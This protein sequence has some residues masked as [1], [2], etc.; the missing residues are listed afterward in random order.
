M[1]GKSGLR[2][3]IP[4]DSEFDYSMPALSSKDLVR[5]KLVSYTST[6]IYNNRPK[7]IDTTKVLEGFTLTD[8]DEVKENPSMI[9]VWPKEAL[10]DKN[11]ITLKAA[12]VRI[13]L[14]HDG[15]LPDPLSQEDVDKYGHD[16]IAKLHP[17]AYAENSGDN[18]TLGF[19]GLSPKI[20]KHTR[21][22]IQIKDANLMRFEIVAS[23]SKTVTPPRAAVG[24]A[25]ATG[26]AFPGS[27]ALTG[28]RGEDANNCDVSKDP[29]N[30]AK[31]V[32]GLA[33]SE[34][35]HVIDDF[36][37]PLETSLP[38]MSANPRISSPAC[39]RIDPVALKQEGIIKYQSGGHK[40]V[41]IPIEIGNPV[42]ASAPGIVVTSHNS[43]TAG[44]YVTLIHEP[45]GYEELPIQKKESMKLL[46]TRYLHLDSRNVNVGD[47]VSAGQTIGVSGNTGERTTGPHLHYEL[48]IFFDVRLK[49]HKDKNFD[50]GASVLTPFVDPSYN[51]AMPQNLAGKFSE[52]Y[53]APYRDSGAQM[54]Y[55]SKPKTTSNDLFAST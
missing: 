17:L 43:E 50:N 19:F 12:R 49:A 1:A 46:Y 16:E 10:Q 53:S 18:G 31:V 7:T 30:A 5:D 47:K 11:T 2:Q 54:S 55:V 4:S 51:G 3:G 37:D 24:S 42:L 13:P 41:D 29:A 20:G 36:Y 8:L 38:I 23:L 9:T 34:L 27:R 14:I 52:G 21:V 32:R 35:Y 15:F 26:P 48:R 28:K 22:K 25:G 45:E 44:N 33:L 40:G 39:K 6:K